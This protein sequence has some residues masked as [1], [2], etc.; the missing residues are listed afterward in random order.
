MLVLRLDLFC[1]KCAL[2]CGDKAYALEMLRDALA[3]ANRVD[4]RYVPFIL[5]ALSFARRVQP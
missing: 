5:R 1:A 3:T 4:K 2:E